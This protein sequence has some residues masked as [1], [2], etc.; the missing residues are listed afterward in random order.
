MAKTTS[1]GK[2]C[3]LFGSPVQIRL[4]YQSFMRTGAPETIRAPDS[5]V[6]VSCSRRAASHRFRSPAGQQ[7]LNSRP[8]FPVEQF[9][10]ENNNPCYH[11]FDPE[12]RDRRFVRGADVQMMP[13]VRR[14]AR[15][16]TCSTR[17]NCP[18]KASMKEI[19]IEAA[20]SLKRLKT[21]MGGYSAKFTS[22]PFRRHVR[23][24]LAPP[25]HRR[26]AIGRI[27]FRRAPILA[28]EI[29]VFCFP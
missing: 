10:S 2:F 24:G 23:N 7:F 15:K 18:Q 4:S 28:S 20:K 5:L 29:C 19:V 25:R 6:R 16:T 27:G 3:L 21:A 26:G 13:P 8:K 22:M 12:L 9:I 1:D 14:V 11:A 17:F